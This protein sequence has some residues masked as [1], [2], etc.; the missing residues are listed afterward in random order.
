MRGARRFLLSAV[1]LAMTVGLTVATA[2]SRGGVPT[3]PSA[4]AAKRSRGSAKSQKTSPIDFKR[5]IR[6]IL[7][8]RCVRC[9][10]S[11]TS[12]GGLRLDSRRNLLR[13]NDSGEPAVVPGKS[14][15]SELIVRII[16]DD[17][18]E[19]MPQEAKRLGDREITL[20]RT[21]IDTGA[22]W[23]DNDRLRNRHWAY[24]HPV[25]SP[26]PG[27]KN[28]DWTRNP[29]D[30]FV[31][32]R[33]E[34]E[35]VEPSPRAEKARL[36]RRVS[37]DLI[38]LPPSPEE[39]AAFVHDSRPDAYE[40][41]VDRL[42]DSPRYGERW[43]RPWLDLAR[44]ADTNGYQA[45]QFRSV[46]PYRDWVIDALN[47]DM[48]FDRFTI[49]QIA[50]D[51][52]PGAG[53]EQKIA[54]GFHR[55]TTCNVEAGVDPEENRVNQIFDRVITTG[56]VWLGTTFQCA[57]CHNHKYDPFTMKDYYQLFAF[58]N[59]TLLE[60]KQLGKGSVTFDFYGPSMK[61][62]LQAEQRQRLDHLNRQCGV[63]EQDPRLKGIPKPLRR[64]IAVPPARRTKRQ[65][66]RLK[67]ANLK[68]DPQTVAFVTRLEMLEKQRA[69]IQPT[70]S[71]VMVETNTPRR[72]YILKRGNFLRRGPQVRP[73]APEILPPLP[74]SVPPNRLGLARWLVDPA[75]PLVGR[76][77]V[78]RWWMEFLG[79]GIVNTPEDFGTQGDR[80]THPKLLDWLA[81]EFVRRG[82]SMKHIHRLIVTSAT[83]RQSSRVTPQMLA[84]DPYNKLYARGPRVRLSAEAIRDNALAI[85][86]LLSPKMHGPPVYPPQPPGIWR[87]I[88]RNE[89]KYVTSR[90]L[91]RHRRGLYVVW[92]R[93]APYPSFVSFDAPDR[94]S[95][96]VRRSRTNTPLQ[97]LTLMNDPVYV[98]LARALAER[99]LTDHPDMSLSQR[100]DYAFRL[101]LARSPKPS[102]ARFLAKIYRKQRARF[103]ANPQAARKLAAFGKRPTA[104]DVE[105]WAA[106]IYVSNILL[107]LDETIT[108]G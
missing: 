31:L 65:K 84:H 89:P 22:V 1:G 107:N 67:K 97:A 29:I 43:A 86:G 79:R 80:P 104:A 105:R 75:N 99:L 100:I 44:Y 8:K 24:V 4:A 21:W 3:A 38:G 78:N 92:R 106:W 48:P 66:Q 61:L 33:L 55:C 5:D 57:Q 90:G 81:V 95:C 82:W 62:P 59:N 30:R 54:T 13:T 14:A 73:A 2:M 91:D 64:I 70:T 42:L 87:H 63:M 60:V 26:L 83:Y 36:I 12:K 9:H 32:A 28:L 69:S 50:G 19:R 16:S 51:L 71:L 20:L 17:D 96:V 6:P 94:A 40:R 23:P 102:E 52:L 56:T 41:L 49:E 15:A 18:D 76:V 85:S 74:K 101:C 47:R 98:E 10:G 53:L 77:T 68:L 34:R 27:V 37:L 88:G 72:S 58:F 39:V 7:E 11:K 25:Q 108:K 45:D 35:G 103:H 93:S 46:W